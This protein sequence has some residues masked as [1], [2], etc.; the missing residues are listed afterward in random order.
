MLAK[1]INKVLNKKGFTLIEL[2]I[3]LAILLIV[4]SVGYSFYFYVVRSF[5][6]ASKQSN[7]QQNV[8]LAKNIIEN[9][10]RYASYIKIGDAPAD[11]SKYNQRIYVN[12]NKIM[13]YVDGEN[14][15]ILNGLSDGVNM[16]L[17]FI[18]LS[19]DSPFL[20]IE[21]K[22]DINGDQ[23]YSISSE[24]LILGI[25]NEKFLGT[26]GQEI[27]FYYSPD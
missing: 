26:D 27:Y 14:K 13:H 16:H 8:R 23:E 21:V 25:N 3:S 22:G 1:M 12:N 6:V 5:D 24:I 7:V 10:V 19:N 15:D 2:L 18:K 20:W 11:S 9:Q 4:L 17:L